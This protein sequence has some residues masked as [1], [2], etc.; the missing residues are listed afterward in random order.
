MRWEDERYVRVYSR[1]TIDWLGLSFEAQA[2]FVLLLRKVDRAGVLPLGKH[3][4][5]GVALAIGHVREWPRLEPALEELLTD[6]CVRT[7]ADGASLVVPNFIA[8][9]EAR[10][11][12]KA[13]QQKARETARDLAAANDVTLRDVKSQAVTHGHA[14]SHRV[15]HDDAA[16]HAVTPSLA[17]PSLAVPTYCPPVVGPPVA[18]D[19]LPDDTDDAELLETPPRPELL[20]TPP[21]APKAARTRKQAVPKSESRGDPRHHPLGLRL[22]AAFQQVTGR[23]YGYG[24]SDAKS[25]TNLLAL[26]D[27][28]PRT[29]GE[30]AGAEIERRWRIGL[31][32]VWKGGEKPV[33]TLRALVSR[34]NDCGESRPSDGMRQAAGGGG[35]SLSVADMPAH[36]LRNAGTHHDTLLAIG[37]ADIPIP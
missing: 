18:D 33:Q 3:G 32:W 14:G 8:A 15:T 2:L 34:W 16:S 27:Q 37:D 19:D 28:D 29:T 20:L 21:D 1:D 9:Q 24:G 26:A 23:A 11:S 36:V 10:S 31:A 4:K 35:A 7:S 13:R 12:D 5:R 22:C 30:Q 25:V 6:G 17:V